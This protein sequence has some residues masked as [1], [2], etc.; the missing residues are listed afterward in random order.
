MAVCSSPD[1]RSVLKIGGAALVA[2]VT[3]AAS[4]V[5]ATPPNRNGDWHQ[6]TATE[7]VAALRRRKVSATELCQAMID[8][9]ERFDPMINAVV[10]RDF[11]RALADARTAD[12]ALRR[13]DR[14]PLLGVPMTVKEGFDLQGY[15]TTMAVQS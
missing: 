3:G 11:E 12:G 1:R 14:R 13:G 10:V 2:T 6:A 4:A 15:P 9:I 7:L 5:A 8:R